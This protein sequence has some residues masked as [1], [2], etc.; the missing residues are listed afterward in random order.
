MQKKDETKK[1]EE[2]RQKQ[3]RQMIKSADGSARLLHKIT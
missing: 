3:V 2:E 1:M